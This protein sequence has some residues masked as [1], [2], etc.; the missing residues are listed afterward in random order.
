MKNFLQN[1]L[2]KPDHH[3][4]NWALVMATFFSVFIFVSFAFYRGFL[5]FGG[6]YQIAEQKPTVELASV[7]SVPTPIQSTKDTFT[8]AFKEIDNQYQQ[9][10]DSLSAVFVPFITGIEVYERK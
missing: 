3:R 1:I 2:E 9:F 4:E 5:S 6:D 7:A 8:N 10:K